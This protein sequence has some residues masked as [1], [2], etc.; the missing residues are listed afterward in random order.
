L[1]RGFGG[2]ARSLPNVIPSLEAL[3]EI[4]LLDGAPILRMT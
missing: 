4:V 3:P 2:I 1:R